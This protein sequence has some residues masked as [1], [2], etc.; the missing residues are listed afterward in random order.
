M[1][2]QL[3]KQ[4][5]NKHVTQV[6]WTPIAIPTCIFKE[7]PCSSKFEDNESKTDEHINEMCS[8]SIIHSHITVLYPVQQ[9]Y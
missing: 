3:E 5:G 1:K 9:G 2:G 4:V 7:L 8:T 6:F